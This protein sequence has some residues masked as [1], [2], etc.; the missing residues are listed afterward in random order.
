[1]DDVLVIPASNPALQNSSYRFLQS[2]IILNNARQGESIHNMRF[3]Y[4]YF[5]KN[6]GL[7][8]EDIEQ[9]LP[10]SQA[11]PPPFSGDPITENQMLMTGKPVHANVQQDHHAHMMVHSMIL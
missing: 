10:P 7:S 1:M 2:E 5:Y 6:M 4:E 8:P 9:L 11:N 3:A